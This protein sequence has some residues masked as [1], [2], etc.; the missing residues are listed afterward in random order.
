MENIISIAYT[1]QWNNPEEIKG[2]FKEIIE[3][4]EVIV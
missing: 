3:H 1:E 2:F 4:W